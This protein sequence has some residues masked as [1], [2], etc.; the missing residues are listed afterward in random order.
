MKNLVIM[1][2]ISGCGSDLSRPMPMPDADGDSDA[3]SDV[4]A[5]V[6]L[7]ASVSDSGRTLTERYADARVSC[8][9]CHPADKC[10]VGD[11][12][13]SSDRAMICDRCIENKPECGTLA[14]DCETLDC[15]EPDAGSGG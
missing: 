3:D 10:P 1:L 14:M 2:F 7:D 12:D 15:P 5:D 6:T 9:A 8:R 11:N 13:E 4:D